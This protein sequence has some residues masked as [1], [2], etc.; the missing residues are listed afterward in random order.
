MRYLYLSEVGWGY[1][2]EEGRSGERIPALTMLESRLKQAIV[3]LNRAVKAPRATRLP[4]AAVPNGNSPV[5]KLIALHETAQKMAGP[6]PRI[7]ELEAKV[8][9]LRTWLK[10]QNCVVEADGSINWGPS[11]RTVVYDHDLASRG[12]TQLRI[13]GGRLFLDDAGA[14]PLDTSNMVTFFSGPGHAIFVMSATG[15]IHVSSHSVGHRHHSS[16]LAGQNVAGAGELQASKG[17]ITWLSNKSGHYRPSVAHLL[18]ILHQL[19]KGG[20]AMSFALTVMPYNKRYP[21]VGAFLK[22]LEL[23]DQPDYELMKLMRYSA[24]LTDDVLGTHIPDPWR[25]RA[26]ER[27]EVPAVYSTDSNQP[28]DHKIVRKWLKSK[29]KVAIGQLQ[30]GDGR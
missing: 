4:A 6:S 14:K 16:L 18:Q 22:A 12:M 11:N 26:A 1:M 5:A 29:G 3:D 8:Q 28:V 24:H 19:Q 30:S 15:N 7:A 17:N 13:I 25:W 23:D 21:T 20:V 2:G 27:G 10:L 9:R